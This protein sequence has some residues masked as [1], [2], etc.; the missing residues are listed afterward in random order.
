MPNIQLC[1]LMLLR[2]PSCRN[3]H[4]H[5]HIYLLKLV[6]LGQTLL[7][8]VGELMKIHEQAIALGIP[9]LGRS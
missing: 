2:L 3:F 1:N 7:K 6:F 9:W 4:T 8:L 5:A